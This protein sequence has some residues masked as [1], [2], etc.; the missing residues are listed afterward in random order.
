MSYAIRL[1]PLSPLECELMPSSRTVLAIPVADLRSWKFSS[2]DHRP[3]SAT[4]VQRD[5]GP[6]LTL[7]P[8]ELSQTK[9]ATRPSPELNSGHSRSGRFGAKVV[10]VPCAYTPYVSPRSW[11]VRHDETSCGHT[12]SQTC[13]CIPTR[14]LFL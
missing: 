13:L 7:V 2:T 14:A 4:T 9:P 8:F 6:S 10:V 12:R 5:I 1:R 11:F 3:M